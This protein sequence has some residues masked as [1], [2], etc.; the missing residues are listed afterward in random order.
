MIFK[1]TELDEIS[2]GW[3]EETEEKRREFVSSASHFRDAWWRQKSW[4][5]GADRTGSQ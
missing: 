5:G 1:A 3:D 2:K 4:Q